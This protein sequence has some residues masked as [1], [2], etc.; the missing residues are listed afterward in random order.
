M[1]VM[2]ILMLAMTQVS[3]HQAVEEEPSSETD[4][5]FV[6]AAAVV[7]G[8]IGCGVLWDQ[9]IK[10]RLLCP[11]FN[12]GRHGKTLSDII[13]Y[14][15]EPRNF[16]VAAPA[17]VAGG[18]LSV[19]ILIASVKK[20]INIA[21]AF[22]TGTGGA[23]AAQAVSV[24]EIPR[25]IAQTAPKATRML[26]AAQV[27]QA[28]AATSVAGSATKASLPGILKPLGALWFPGTFGV[29]ATMCSAGIVSTELTSLAVRAWKSPAPN[30]V[31]VMFDA[32]NLN[33]WGKD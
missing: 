11:M 23:S 2:V 9:L 14:E 26:P 12:N 29:V 22:F 17:T 5:A 33:T 16:E 4:I 7:L 8:S 3:C 24:T 25:H 28:Y 6:P 20:L 21:G 31:G 10:K 18:I 19:P 30:F 13:V 1:S 32:C 15:T 27:G